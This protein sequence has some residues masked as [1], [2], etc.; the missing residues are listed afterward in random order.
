MVFSL[1]EVVYRQCGSDNVDKYSIIRFV[2]HFNDFRVV[3]GGV[4]KD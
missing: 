3:L 2:H 1:S 4:G